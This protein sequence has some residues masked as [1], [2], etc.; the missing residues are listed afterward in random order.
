MACIVLS[1]QA[2]RFDVKPLVDGLCANGVNVEVRQ[3]R[4]IIMMNIMMAIIIA[5]AAMA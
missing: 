5:R 1:C 4:T 2:W 3:A